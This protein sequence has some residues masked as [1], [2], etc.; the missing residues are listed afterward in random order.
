MEVG[1]PPYQPPMKSFGGSG[2][3]KRLWDRF[4]TDALDRVEDGGWLV[5]MHPSGWRKPDSELYHRMIT[6]GHFKSIRMLSKQES[7]NIMGVSIAVDAYV[8]QK[9]TTGKTTVTDTRGVKTTWNLPKDWPYFLPNYNLREIYDAKL[10]DGRDPA[11]VIFSVTLFGTYGVRREHISKT[12]S[13]KFKYP[14]IHAVRKSDIGYVWSSRNTDKHGSK[15]HF[16][17]PKVI[18]GDN[19]Q[20]KQAIDDFDG[21]YACSQHAIGLPTAGLGIK[22]RT[23]LVNALTSTKFNDFLLACRWSTHQIDWRLFQYLRPDWYE[24]FLDND[25]F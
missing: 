18:I 23:K 12:K 1:N 14:V 9:G 8:W 2:T 16:G 25:T 21:K 11:R 19:D 13:T 5:Y 22:A 24:G 6:E 4:L 15:Q 10:F 20:V 3:G 7:K 17:V